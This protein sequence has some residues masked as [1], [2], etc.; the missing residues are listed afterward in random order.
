MRAKTM[1]KA[2]LA[3]AAFATGSATGLTAYVNGDQR[4]IRERHV[5]VS[6]VDR[7]GKPVTDLTPQSFTVREEGVVREVLAV[8]P[9]TT[10]MNVALLVDTSDGINTIV[11]DLRKG[12]DGFV[13]AIYAKQPMTQMAIMSFGK[14]PTI[15][16]DYAGS[17]IGVQTGI[18]RIFARTG[19][20][21]YF[22]EA[23]L[24][25]VKGLKKRQAVR[26]IIV[27]FLS[28]TSP[29]F[30]PQPREQIADALKSIGAELWVIT[31]QT[32]SISSTE[33]VRNRAAVIGD[34]TTMSGGTND[35]MLSQLAIPQKFVDVAERLNGQLDVTYGRPESMI[36]P[37][38]LE[39][40]VKRDGLR[41]L[42][43]HWIAK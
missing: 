38:H 24:E 26:P 28:E 8:A 21:S 33:E 13:K 22:L 14:R 5:I 43:P 29:E 27:G 34:V 31:L 12:L 42:F 2:I 23:I 39:V 1:T 41:V 10:P 17:A 19:S 11:Q 15:E 25:A 36:P 6:V 35:A 37:E 7:D 20:G 32:R 9:A 3:L 18:Q 30:S 40:A 4:A 16:S